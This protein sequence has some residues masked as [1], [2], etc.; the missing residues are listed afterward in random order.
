MKNRR[1][2]SIVLQASRC[3]FLLI[4]VTVA[5][6]NMCALAADQVA[7]Q[8]APVARKATSTS[9][10]MSV[11]R[12]TRTTLPES[13]KRF[14]EA[15]WGIDI[16]GVKS[17]ESGSMLRFSYTVVDPEKAQV[18]NDKKHTPYLYDL[19]TRVRLEVPSMEKVGQLRQSSP[20]AAGHTYWMVFANQQRLVKPGTRVDISI[21]PFRAQGLLVE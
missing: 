5:G 17:V 6:N 20:V 14:Y 11:R 3:A 12:M 2:Y 8:S 15:T 18:L 19:D 16:V 1:E 9:T 10:T 7:G 21:G 4:A 13:A